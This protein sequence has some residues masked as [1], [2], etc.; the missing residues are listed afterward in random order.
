MRKTKFKN[1]SGSVLG[2]L[3]LKQI[4][5]KK[6]LCFRERTLSGIPHDRKEIPKFLHTVLYSFMIT[7]GYV[8]PTLKK[9]CLLNLK[10]AGVQAGQTFDGLFLGK[11]S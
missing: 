6:L 10:L 1:F 5:Q 7:T 2:E 11:T 8:Y 9:Y 3:Q 4:I